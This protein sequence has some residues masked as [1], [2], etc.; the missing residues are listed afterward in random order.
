MKN[1]FKRGIISFTLAISVLSN[2]IPAYA[3][4]SSSSKYCDIYQVIESNPKGTV[5]VEIWLSGFDEN[6]IEQEAIAAMIKS[7]EE[8]KNIR[9]SDSKIAEFNDMCN[10][11]FVKEQAIK[12]STLSGN[13]SATASIEIVDTYISTK[14]NVLRE[15]IIEANTQFCEKWLSNCEINYASTYAPVIICTIDKN[16]LNAISHCDNVQ[17]VF[18]FDNSECVD[19]VISLDDLENAVLG[20]TQLTNGGSEIIIG[21]IES[22]V[23]NA[24]LCSGLTST[25]INLVDSNDT[26]TT[27]YATAVANILVGNNGVAPSAT[28]WSVQLDGGTFFAAVDELVA[29][30]VNIINMSSGYHGSRQGIYDT[31]SKYVD[32][33]VNTCNICFV[34]SS[35]NQT[36]DKTMIGSPGMAYNAITVGNCNLDFSAISSTSIYQESNGIAEKPDFIAPGMSI[37]TEVD[38]YN[39]KSGTSFSTPAVAGAIAVLMYQDAN[40]KTRPH[41]VKAILAAGADSGSVS[42]LMSV[43]GVLTEEAGAGMVNATDADAARYVVRTTSSGSLS[44]ETGMTIAAG[45]KVRIAISWKKLNTLASG[46]TVNNAALNQYNVVVKQNN[47]SIAIVNDTSTYNN[48]MIVFDV[49]ATVTAKLQIEI[50]NS[51]SSNNQSLAISYA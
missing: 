38:N 50:T 20:G 26:N 34:K 40:L 47:S 51:S 39:T 25:D 49:T 33:I 37:A 17:D 30:N 12:D 1:S 35:G 7:S 45:E 4:D 27:E 23:P 19:D 22:G 15:K 8:Y 13:T 42:G 11:L 36:T 3:L 48:N 14:R 18:I 2:V 46:T 43:F 29:K 5:D 9:F 32:Y 28:L 21:Q 6:K 10:D 31:Y 16:N 44:Y 41:L 24:D